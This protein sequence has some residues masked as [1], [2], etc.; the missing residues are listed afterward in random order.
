MSPARVGLQYGPLTYP[1]VNRTPCDASESMFGV[2]MSLHPLAP[3]SAYPRSSATISRIFGLRPAAS[4]ASVSPSNQAT[5][6]QRA[7]RRRTVGGGAG[8][9][10]MER[11]L[12]STRSVTATARRLQV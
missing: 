10:F 7:A 12:I 9:T 6:R 3:M 4:A 1:L 2:G 5:A 11:D 8:M